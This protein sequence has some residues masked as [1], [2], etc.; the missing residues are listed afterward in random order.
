VLTHGLGG[1]SAGIW[2]RAASELADEFTVV[3]YDL[4]GTG[5]SERGP[6]PYSL[7]DFVGDLRAL[8]EELELAS[9]ALVGHS[10]GGSITLA[11]AARHPEEVS[12]VASAGGPVVLPEQGQQGMRDRA[13]KVENEGMASV[14]ETVAAN[15]TAPSFRERDPGGFDALVAMLAA[16]DP[17]TYAATC[18]V[19]AELD[20][21]PE[22]GRVT[23]PV[24]LVAGDRDGVV[25][26][27]AGDEIEAALPL[28]AR[29]VTVE[30]CGHN[31]T[32]E[33]PELL[34]DYVR[35]FLRDR[36]TAPA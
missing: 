26:P 23:A 13:E 21:R 33:R 17:A 6:G 34:V 16:N 24:L 10:F 35:S 5:G 20:L 22:L 8:V 36:V 31:V 11:Y 7:D 27:A 4:R 18:R 9:P 28:V 12:A 15:G 19:I 3:T 29:R 14:A 1:T 2:G 30:D 32:V 25:P